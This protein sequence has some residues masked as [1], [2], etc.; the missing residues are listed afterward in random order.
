M[1]IREPAVPAL[2]FSKCSFP[3]LTV[4]GSW[5][6]AWGR[7]DQAGHLFF[8]PS[9][10]AFVDAATSSLCPLAL[11]AL[12]ES[13]D[14]PSLHKER[15]EHTRKLFH[16]LVSHLAPG[17]PPPWVPIFFLHNDPTSFQFPRGLSQFC[18]QFWVP[19]SSFLTSVVGLRLDSLAA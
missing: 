15:V 11:D 8:L 4:C 16:S 18:L 2:Q 10:T 13:K 14:P 17:P 1:P 19:P 5:G 6:W 9:W 3:R 12:Q 7:Q